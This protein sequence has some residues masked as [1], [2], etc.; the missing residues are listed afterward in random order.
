MVGY[1]DKVTKTE[2]RELMEQE[3]ELSESQ[4]FKDVDE[5]LKFAFDDNNT[6]IEII[7]GDDEG[8]VSLTEEG[9]QLLDADRFEQEAFR[10]LERKSRTNFTY[11]HRTIGAFDDKVHSGKYGL[12]SSL[13]DEINTLMTEGEGGNTVTAGTIGGILQSFGIVEKVDNGYEINPS[14]YT[15]L[16]G[17]DRTL[18][19]EIIRE[20]DSE[21][22]YSALED[23]AVMTFGWDISRL[24]EVVSALEADNEVRVYRRGG[25]EYIQLLS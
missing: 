9:R 13:T 19:K 1:K 11:F 15:N 24:E 21:M 22:S 4:P 20:E 23:K 3:N 7:H 16:R 14:I 2:L 18:I 25:K 6:S 8:V 12:G 5:W 10:L 17:D